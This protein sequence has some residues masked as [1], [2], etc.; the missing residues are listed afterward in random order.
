MKNNSLE[1]E[2]K[3]QVI[4]ST[5]ECLFDAQTRFQH[6][7]YQPNDMTD[8]EKIS[9]S[10][11]YLLS[12]HK[13]IS[14]VLDCL[15]WKSHRK[16]ASKEINMEEL[17]SEL[18]DVVKFLMNVMYIWSIDSKKFVEAFYKK[19]K[20]VEERYEREKDHIKHL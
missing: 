2:R 8:D 19:S 12:A 10:K 16:Y 15:P 14:E 1:E 4:D 6:H 5:V 9:L 13:E 3:G 7:F 11:E 17:E 18:I 20:E